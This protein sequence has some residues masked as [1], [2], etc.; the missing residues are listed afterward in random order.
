M[1]EKRPFL[2]DGSQFGVSRTQFRRMRKA[3]KRERMV[4]WFRQ[5]FEDPAERTS[6]VSA[7]GGR[8]PARQRW[9]NRLVQIA[10]LVK[11]FVQW[12]AAE[13]R[14]PPAVF[15]FSEPQQRGNDRQRLIDACDRLVRDTSAR[16]SS[17]IIRT[18]CRRSLACK[19]SVNLRPIW[20]STRRINGF[21][22]EMSEGGTT[23]YSVVGLTSAVRSAILQ[24]Q[25]R[26]TWATTG[27][28]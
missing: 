15:D 27:S 1:A 14:R 28:R 8:G 5:N 20:F 21:V 17:S 19:S 12:H 7:E 2:E 26:V 13:G 10:D 16:N 4:Q 11:H 23:R 3:E 25:R 24:S 6:Y 18:R 9:E 22:R